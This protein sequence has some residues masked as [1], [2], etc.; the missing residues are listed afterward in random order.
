LAKQERDG[1]AMWE[2]RIIAYKGVF[3]DGEHGVMYTDN[4]G[5]QGSMGISFLMDAMSW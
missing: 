2:G 3:S 1:K 4:S 5:D